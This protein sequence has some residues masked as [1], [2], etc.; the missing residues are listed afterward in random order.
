[1]DIQH[2]SLLTNPDGTSPLGLFLRTVS[3]P[4]SISKKHLHAMMNAGDRL[5]VSSHQA[6][7]GERDQHKTNATDQYQSDPGANKRC[8]LSNGAIIHRIHPSIAAVRLSITAEIK[9]PNAMDHPVILLWAGQQLP[10]VR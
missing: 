3:L 8:F 2:G 4:T 5:C 7:D 10:N 9:D 1:M 6:V